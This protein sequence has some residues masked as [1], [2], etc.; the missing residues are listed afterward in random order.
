MST[1]DNARTYFQAFVENHRLEYFELMRELNSRAYGE[2]EDRDKFIQLSREITHNLHETYSD[3]SIGGKF[4]SP[5]V[6]INSIKQFRK[7][8]LSFD[9]YFKR[10]L[11]CYKT[12]DYLPT[13]IQEIGRMRFETLEACDYFLKLARKDE[14]EE[15]YGILAGLEGI[16]FGQFLKL[17]WKL[18]IKILITIVGPIF[19]LGYGIGYGSGYLKT[20]KPLTSIIGYVADPSLG[21]GKDS[22]CVSDLSVESPVDLGTLENL[23]IRSER[24]TILWNG[25]VSV[26]LSR[27]LSQTVIFRGIVGWAREPKESDAYYFNTDCR[28]ETGEQIYIK[29]LNGEIWKMNVLQARTTEIIIDLLLYQNPLAR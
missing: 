17:I 19:A 4:P 5:D 25:E 6:L 3:L 11:R 18:K 2:Y 29:R 10:A 9:K 26:M 14:M 20:E 21:K 12:A 13:P 22:L 24:A 16:T 28:V 27:S 15:K 23:T 8:L 1:L 7:L